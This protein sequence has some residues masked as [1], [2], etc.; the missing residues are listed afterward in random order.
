N[1][2]FCNALSKYLPGLN[3]FP[4]EIDWNEAE[5]FLNLPAVAAVIIHNPDHK[6]LNGL[7][8]LAQSII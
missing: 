4:A 3:L 7:V 1:L 5:L 8:R 2:T 6:Q